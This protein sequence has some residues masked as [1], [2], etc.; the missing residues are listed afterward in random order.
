[1]SFVLVEALT[2][3]LARFVKAA[4][5]LNVQLHLLTYNKKLYF[6]ELNHIKSEHLTVIEL[7][8][9][10]HAKIITYRQNLKK[11][12]EIINLTDT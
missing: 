5:T 10:N 3:G 7:D 9:F 6:Y 8:R 12:G 11:F 1:M 2:F 4:E